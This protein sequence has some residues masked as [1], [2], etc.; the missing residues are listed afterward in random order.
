MVFFR[1]NAKRLP[2]GR[3]FRTLYEVYFGH[4]ASK[5]FVELG[6]LND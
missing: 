5:E 2:Q 1:N 4:T 6:N 3:G